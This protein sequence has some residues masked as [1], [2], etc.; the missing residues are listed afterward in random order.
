MRANKRLFLFVV[1]FF[2]L[3][4]TGALHAQNITFDKYHS[5]Q[6]I[7]AYLKAIQAKYSHLARISS[8][9]KSLLG[10]EIWVIEITN[11]KLKKPGDKPA[12]YI[13]G[14]THGNEVTGT[15]VCL[16]TIDYLVRNY[17]KDERI[18][19]L[20]DTRTFYIAP[21]VN[22]DSN[23][24][25]VTTPIRSLR[26]NQ[27]PFDDDSDGKVDEDPAED[28]NGDG[29]ITMM[30]KKDP[31]EGTIVVHPDDPRIMV[32]PNREK[33]ERGTYKIWRSEGID[34]DGDGKIN[35]DSKGGVNIN[36][37]YPAYW[38]PAHKQR[39]GGVYPLSEPESRAIVEFCLVHSNI[40]TVQSYHTSGGFLFQPLAAEKISVIPQE[41]RAVFK[42]ISEAY[43][44]A[45]GNESRRPYRERGPRPGPYGFG[46]FI[47]W[48][49]MHLGA[50]SGTTELWSL[51]DKYDPEKQK[52]KKAEGAASDE[53]NR[54]LERAKA[55]F[56]FI[57][58]ELG[59]EGFVSWKS[60]QHP[61]LGKIEI[62]GWKKFVRSNP[63]PKFLKQVVEKN[64]MADVAQAE[65]TP[66]VLI[67]EVK[68]DL[69]QGGENAKH[70][71]IKKIGNT[72]KASQGKTLSER[73]AIF[74]VTATVRNKGPVQS[75]TKKME[76]TR[77]PQRP[78]VSDLLILEPGKNVTL[79]AENARVRLGSLAAKNE[80]S[81]KK[82]AS[83][84]VQLKGKEGRLKIISISQK[85]GR[86]EKTI[87][88]R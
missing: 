88:L 81:D 58:E 79:L 40:A 69:V 67:D 74:E 71:S 47:D 23:D 39:R 22:P 44:K 63:P 14:G 49:Y 5:Y 10:K 38:E 72:L 4:M 20:L 82:S 36:R 48:A 87:S 56:Q 75:I 61:T 6:E 77:L 64:T 68:L 17:G 54:S 9:G 84:L 2:C 16:H 37:N 76:T 19:I 55:W 41:D 32:R 78:N 60:F 66:L 50:Y 3:W 83:W 29:I 51:P 28:L 12:M 34:N 25:F 33:G 42:K 52:K 30:R 35:E 85:G 73:I 27:R 53:Y 18:T 86:D 15:E 62:G 21:S 46:I 31:E 8:M 1:S 43:K 26:N 70:V 7:T 24:L 57:D 80:N 45:T 13:D 11:R 65:L 59:G